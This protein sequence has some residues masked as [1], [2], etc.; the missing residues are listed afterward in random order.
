MIAPV[1][2]KAAKAA[3]DT[4]II[5]NRIF[6]TSRPPPERTAWSGYLATPWALLDRPCAKV[7]LCGGPAIHQTI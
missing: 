2:I 6:E 4:A 3:T 7:R 5:A 1:V